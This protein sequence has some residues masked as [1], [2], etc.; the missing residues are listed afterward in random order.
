MCYNVR[1]RI[2]ACGIVGLA[3]LTLLLSGCKRQDLGS[4]TPEA[5]SEFATMQEELMQT[6]HEGDMSEDEAAEIGSLL[7]HFEQTA[8]ARFSTQPSGLTILHLACMYKHAELARCLLQDGAAANAPLRVEAF[9]TMSEA[10]ATPLMLAVQMP[11]SCPQENML[12]LVQHLLNA[13]A[14]VNMHREGQLCAYEQV[15]CT[16]LEHAKDLSDLPAGGDAEVQ[17]IGRIAAESGWL[18]GLQRLLDARKGQLTEGDKLLLHVLAGN[19]V[20]DKGYTACAKLLLERGIPA[21]A[22]DARGASPL[23]TLTTGAAFQQGDGLNVLEMTELLLKHGADPYRI[24]EHDPEFPGFMPYDF[25]LTKPELVAELRRR[26][27]PLEA[28]P[29]QW[30]TPGTLPREI[31]R[32]HLRE[33]ALSGNTHATPDGPIYTLTRKLRAE[34]SPALA[35]RYD[36]IAR[37]LTPDSTMLQD[38]LYVD[39]LRAGIELLAATD[40]PRTARLLEAMPL[41]QDP[42][43]WKDQHPHALAVLQAV[44]DA[45]ALVLSKELICRAAETMEQQMQH[46]MAATMLELLGRCS[47]ADAEITHYSRDTRPAMQAGAMQALLLQAGLPPARCYG[48]RDWLTAHGMKADTPVRRKAEL[49]TSQED[50]WFGTMPEPTRDELCRSMEEIGAPNAAKAYRA[51]AAALQDPD[52]LDEITAD[53][54][55]WKF[56]LEIATARYILAHKKDFLSPEPPEKQ[57]TD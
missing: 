38:P 12:K 52:R 20:E 27:Y 49:L 32:A 11:P 22:P 34:I 36:T 45:P 4:A 5:A 21:D 44:A 31:C 24:A 39:A 42:L 40:A 35:E 2:Q 9:T 15:Y 18:Q 46:D 55:L 10:A 57:I 43:V 28:P 53:S 8:D 26:G 7:T 47:D 6:L 56:E 37:I 41:W 13:G 29:L 1:M 17:S 19:N 23:F 14:T 33:S 16:L 30:D 3:A 50:L 25:L 51:I 54:H 48:V